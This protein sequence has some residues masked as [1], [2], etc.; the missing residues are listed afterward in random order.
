MPL[1]VAV[2]PAGNIVVADTFNDRIQVFDGAGKFLT[3]FGGSFAKH[4]FKV[5]GQ[6]GNGEG[7]FFCPGGVAVESTGHIFVADTLNSRVQEF[8]QN[9][10]FVRAFGNE[11]RGNGNFF[12]PSAIALTPA[13]DILVADEGNF[14][15]QR[16]SKEGK[17]LFQFGNDGLDNGQFGKLNSVTTTPSGDMVVAEGI[18]VQMFDREGIFLRT[19]GTPALATEETKNLSFPMG[20]A[21]AP[22]GNI[23]VVYMGYTDTNTRIEVFDGDGHFRTK[24]AGK[25]SGDGELKEPFGIAIDRAGNV[26]VAD[27]GNNRIVVFKP[28][29]RRP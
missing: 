10:K 16:L 24:F 8:D 23:I 12:K 6:E 19:I 20:V 3:A 29:A 18:R 14:R 27:K 1:G 11:G 2:S 15:I 25:G 9:G 21:I 7:K 4:R 5:A 26:V 13:G 22:S 17:F 28:V